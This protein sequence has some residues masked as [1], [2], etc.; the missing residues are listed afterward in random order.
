MKELGEVDGAADADGLIS[1]NADEI[2]GEMRLAA[3]AEAAIEKVMSASPQARV[4]RIITW[5]AAYECAS[6]DAR[7]ALG[8][9]ITSF[10]RD[11]ADFIERGDF[12]ALQSVI[13]GMRH[14]VIS[15]AAIGP[16]RA[17][18]MPGPD[19][20]RDFGWSSEERRDLQDVLLLGM[21]G[22]KKGDHV[23]QLDA[24]GVTT[25]AGV[26]LSKGQISAACVPASQGTSRP[27]VEPMPR[28]GIEQMPRR[29]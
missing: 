20:F 4:V 19:T 13:E 22:V 25:A 26:R 1:E 23:V 16:P 28:R 7:I 2:A 27:N 29:S 3:T 6:D 5:A 14:N 11:A 9:Q 17:A 21:C 10:A 18:L 12:G 24:E 15:A 8:N